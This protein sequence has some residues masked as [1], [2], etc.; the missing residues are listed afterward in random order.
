MILKRVLFNYFDDFDGLRCNKR[1][2]EKSHETG[3]MFSIVLL[4]Y[5]DDSDGLCCNK[6]VMEKSH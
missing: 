2:M 1:V 6:R 4:N 3:M 5:V